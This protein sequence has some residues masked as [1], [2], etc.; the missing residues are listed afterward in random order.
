MAAVILKIGNVDLSMI[1]EQEGVRIRTAPVVGAEFTSITGKKH[2]KV[3]GE[4]VDISA[5]FNHVPE[6]MAAKIVSALKSDNVTVEYKDPLVQTAVFDRPTYD[7]V[8]D[9]AA[10]EDERYWNISVSMV[11]PLKGDGL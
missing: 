9:F 3:L 6:D 1:T 5:D 4:S 7:S 11:C 8:P 10:S 2:K